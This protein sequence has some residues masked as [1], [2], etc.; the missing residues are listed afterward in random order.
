MECYQERVIYYWRHALYGHVKLICD[1]GIASK[2]SNLFLYIYKSLADGIL[3]NT[4]VALNSIQY[5]QA[6]TDL[7]LI[8]NVCL[9]Y[10]HKNSKDPDSSLLSSL[11]KEITQ[12][13]KSSNPFAAFYAGQILWM[14]NELK[15]AR[16][17]ISKFEDTNSS[18]TLKGWIDV[19]EGNY[20][21]AMTW[22]DLVLSD[23][24]KSFDVLALYGKALTQAALNLSSES[25]QT[26]A[27]ILSRY[28]FPEIHLEKAK[29][30]IFL[31]KWSLTNEMIEEAKK[32]LP[33]SFEA[34]I[35]GIY[36]ALLRDGDT[37]HVISLLDTITKLAQEY[38]SNNIY[39]IPKIAFAIASIFHYDISLLDRSFKLMLIL[40]VTTNYKNRAST[41]SVYYSVLAFHKILTYN[42]K[43]AQE[44]VDLSIELDPTN[45]FAVECQILLHKSLGEYMEADDIREL[46]IS[47]D[48]L[49]MLFNSSDFMALYTN[50]NYPKIK[51]T[52]VRNETPME[53]TIERVHDLFI[54]L[55]FDIIV[56]NMEKLI[57]LNNQDEKKMKS[58][59][60][61][62]IKLGPQY[63]PF[64]FL[65][66]IYY[67]AQRQFDLSL[68][69]FQEIL[70]AK[71]EYRT[72]SCLLAVSQIYFEKEKYEDAYTYLT[73][74][75][76]EDP[77]ILSSLP[78]AFLK[79]KIELKIGNE[80]ESMIHLLSTIDNKELDFREM[81]EVIDIAIQC[82]KYEI[83]AN[84]IRLASGYTHGASDKAELIFRQ[85]YIF[86]YSNRFDRAIETLQK[87]KKHQ[88]F[89]ETAYITEAN[90][91]LIFKKD[92][93][94][95]VQRFLD[96]CKIE[97]NQ[98]N[99]TLLADAL[100]VT[101][102]YEEAI[103]AYRKCPKQTPE[104]TRKLV[105]ALIN[106]HD[107]Q[108]A[109]NLFPDS[110]SLQME[111]IELLVNLKR[112]Q[113]A[114]KM[115][116]RFIRS[117]I[118]VDVLTLI[119]Y[120][121]LMGF[122]L[123]QKKNFQ[124][125]NSNYIK[126]L[127]ILDK[128]ISGAYSVNC[129]VKHIKEVASEICV[130]IGDNF[131]ELGELDQALQ[132]YQH[133]LNFV[134]SNHDPIIR[135]F[136]IYKMRI[137]VEKC[138]NICSK[139]L[140]DNPKDELVVLLYTSIANREYNE[141]INYLTNIL[142][143]NPVAYRSLSRLIELCARSGKTAIASKFIKNAQKINP[144]AAGLHFALGL[145]DWYHDRIESALTHFRKSKLTQHWSLSSQNAMFNILINPEQKYVWQE[146]EPLSTP[147]FIAEAREILD[148]INVN[149]ITR[150]ILGIEI[151]MSVNTSESIEAAFNKVVEIRNQDVFNIRLNLDYAKL[152]IRRDDIQT[153]QSMLDLILK[154][155]P[156]HENFS[157]FEEAY[158]MKGYI[159]SRQS[160][161]HTA[162]HFVF[163][164]LD[165]NMCCKFAWK[166]SAESHKSTKH[167][168]EAANAYS[169]C[170][171]LC[172]YSNPEIGYNYANCL[173]LSNQP[174]Q[175]MTACRMIME[176]FPEFI[177]IKKDI[178]LP[179][180][181]LLKN[182]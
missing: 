37:R 30:Y 11:K 147:G 163:L 101:H 112:Y 67:M 31:D 45:F 146:T 93:E 18:N 174:E 84:Y 143:H 94:A 117:S 105:L 78:I 69:N 70:V 91:Y 161:Y 89:R 77:S 32:E 171:E 17:I 16:Q 115:I 125:S 102:N 76:S 44:N 63:L 110:N 24:Q 72:S 166:I 74:A 180:F 133:S 121:K 182:R 5:L 111:T 126:A 118:N 173:L 66:A 96:L 179:A 81:L 35:I 6:R 7:A 127:D 97:A 43:S 175:A 2:S 14:F 141:S 65:N 139:F 53:I 68:K 149:D 132:Y 114:Q 108:G 33:S 4:E 9:Y 176:L 128:T 104:L 113:E 106:A 1:L 129:Y 82:K 73:E 136:N 135:M 60:D 62:I 140:E 54:S 167:Y 162:Q 22:F 88:T 41:E 13:L 48:P 145:F 151:N 34:D 98:C 131:D 79:A 50:I 156:F 124:E 134:T 42:F 164:A 138:Q 85:A 75:T 23:T 20:S 83:A 155:R 46:Y 28:K 100:C 152:L 107:F 103:F 157:F 137:D 52:F 8:Y 87:L 27:R 29:I 159:L 142:D 40:Q 51:S 92:K 64:K 59:L 49:S 165:L 178:V 169:H 150:D 56:E 158:L 95:Y 3:G 57:F 123:K 26:F 116:D 154:G 119:K 21:S 160:S 122:L 39:Y 86:C 120:H 12:S 55:R 80:E 177:S 148:S 181:K 15:L 19:T 71:S 25:I 58:I 36:G 61:I 172:S 47:I 99:L 153:A 130:L 144:N 38:E 170:W 10:I 109:A 168:A 90:L